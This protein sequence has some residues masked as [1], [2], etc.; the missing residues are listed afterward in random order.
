M[1]AEPAPNINILCLLISMCSV[2]GRANG[3]RAVCMQASLSDPLLNVWRS[4]CMCGDTSE[5]AKARIYLRVT[6]MNYVCTFMKMFVL[7]H[8]AVRISK[9]AC[10]SW[11]TQRKQ[12]YCI[13][14]YSSLLFFHRKTVT[15]RQNPALYILLIC[16]HRAESNGIQSLLAIPPPLLFLLL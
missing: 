1:P 3:P 2:K 5:E 12:M 15:N 14:Q 8:Y 6:D 7:S 4:P 11:Q 16:L 13:R 10:P 9:V